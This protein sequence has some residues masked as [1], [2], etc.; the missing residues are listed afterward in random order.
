MM[1]MHLLDYWMRD[2]PK[3]HRESNKLGHAE[4][5]LVN[6]QIQSHDIQVYGRSTSLRATV[7]RRRGSR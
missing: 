3:S 7:F 5:D 1:L 2:L 4:D 6:V